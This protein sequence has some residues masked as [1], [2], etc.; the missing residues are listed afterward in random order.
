M[1]VD[2]DGSLHNIREKHLQIYRVVPGS[3]ASARHR[4]A[5]CLFSQLRL[6]MRVEDCESAKQ[7]LRPL[8]H[9]LLTVRR[10]AVIAM[11]D[12]RRACERRLA[13]EAVLVEAVPVRMV[14]TL[15]AGACAGGTV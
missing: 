7:L 11:S 9:S 8:T 2:N 4:N 1:R 10:A 5:D 3:I 14:R 12:E 15:S 13:G 6:T